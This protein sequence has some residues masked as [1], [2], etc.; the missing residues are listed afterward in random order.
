MVLLWLFFHFFFLLNVYLGQYGSHS[1]CLS[2]DWLVLTHN[3]VLLSPGAELR[4]VIGSHLHRHAGFS[5][6]WREVFMSGDQEPWIFR[7]GLTAELQVCI[8]T[9]PAGPG[10]NP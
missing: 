3:T 7:G 8:Q 2:C 6:G 1:T 10:R 5:K 4:V 9:P